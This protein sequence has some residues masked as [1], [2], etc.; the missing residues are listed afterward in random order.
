MICC[1]LVFADPFTCSQ[2]FGGKQQAWPNNFERVKG[3]AMLAIKKIIG[4]EIMKTVKMQVYSILECQP[5]SMHT[6]S[7]SREIFLTT[8]G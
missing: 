4:G 3:L 8:F 1:S 6:S 7:K 2:L 5:L